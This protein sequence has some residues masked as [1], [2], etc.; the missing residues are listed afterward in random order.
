LASIG[1]QLRQAREARGISIQDVEQATRI[2]RVFVVALE[3][4][5]L[6]DLPD[7]AY[8][9]G[10]VRNYAR[11]LG[12]DAEPLVRDYAQQAGTREL[13]VPAVLDEPLFV[14]AG[15]GLKVAL[16][17]LLVGLVVT[18]AGWVAYSYLY[19]GQ[20]PW[21]LNQFEWSAW[22]VVTPTGT[23]TP[24]VMPVTP[25]DTPPLTAVSVAPTGTPPP[26]VDSEAPASSPT[27]DADSAPLTGTPAPGAT[28][29]PR[30]TGT[31]P[32]EEGLP[33]A[34]GLTVRLLA[35]G[36]TWLDVYVDEA[37]EF[38]GYLNDGDER[39]WTGERSV[40]LLIGNAA[41]AS[42][43]V[44]GVDVGPLGDAGEVVTLIYEADNLP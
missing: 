30:P 10:F 11:F 32:A 5:R 38:I 34:T 26:T 25:T 39:S 2:R 33:V 7:P 42:I 15:R 28:T 31:V 8:V 16:F 20:T 23:L 9:R 43:E 37:Q 41:V 22:R 40:E 35:S 19:L 3:E 13:E 1:E 27:P 44:N 18:A 24:K 14:R 4:D 17:V 36:Y 29:T 6:Q 21:P 12:L